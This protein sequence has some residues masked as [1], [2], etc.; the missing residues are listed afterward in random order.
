[1]VTLP[2][3]RLRFQRAPA[4]NAGYWHTRLRAP[5]I[6]GSRASRPHHSWELGMTTA[7]R[8]PDALDSPLNIVVRLAR[9]ICIHFKC[10]AA[11]ASITRWLSRLS[12]S[13]SG[14]SKIG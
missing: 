12:M 13:L 14:D 2:A 1:M 9:A 5:L 7:F 8:Q 11:I 3:S 10:N 4:E 6:R